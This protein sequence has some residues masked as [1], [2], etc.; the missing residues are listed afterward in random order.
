MNNKVDTVKAF[1]VYRE[2][3]HEFILIQEKKEICLNH[4]V[5]LKNKIKLAVSEFE[6]DSLKENVFFWKAK[7]K[8]LDAQLDE[9]AY[10]ITDLEKEFWLIVNSEITKW[11]TCRA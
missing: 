10:F 5:D 9:I 11:V 6:A 2:Y 7:I 1:S 4:C 3:K 8:N